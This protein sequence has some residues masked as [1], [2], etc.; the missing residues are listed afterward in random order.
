MHWTQSI[1]VADYVAAVEYL[2]HHVAVVNLVEY[3]AVVN[4]EYYFAVN[5]AAVVAVADSGILVGG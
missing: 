4:L 5:A 1:V 3:L 2:E